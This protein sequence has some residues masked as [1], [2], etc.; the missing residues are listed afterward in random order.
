MWSKRLGYPS[1]GDTMT[2]MPLKD[3]RAQLGRLTYPI[4]ISKDG[5]QQCAPTHGKSILHCFIMASITLNAIL[6][7]LLDFKLSL[8]DWALQDYFEGFYDKSNATQVM[9]IVASCRS[10]SNCPSHVQCHFNPRLEQAMVIQLI[11]DHSW[12]GAAPVRTSEASQLSWL[13]NAAPKLL[14]VDQKTTTQSIIS[15]MPNTDTF[16]LVYLNGL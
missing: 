3:E 13:E 10:S 12:L 1:P 6:P 4:P 2:P 7:L 14:A 16:S 11:L 5:M 8:W 15:G 9:Y